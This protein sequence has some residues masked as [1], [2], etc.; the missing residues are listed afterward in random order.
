MDIR[1]SVPIYLL[2]LWISAYICRYTCTGLHQCKRTQIHLYPCDAAENADMGVCP[3]VLYAKTSVCPLKFRFSTYVSTDPPN[4]P[5]PA[6]ISVTS[7]PSPAPP[8][9]SPP[10]AIVLGGTS[11]PPVHAFAAHSL[12]HTVMHVP[13]Y[14]TYLR[15]VSFSRENIQRHAYILRCLQT[16]SNR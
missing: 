14:V 12:T 11:A 2:H 10:P 7:L 4:L 9:S 16:D 13:G 6:P 15:A 8:P 5:A 3:Y 1:I